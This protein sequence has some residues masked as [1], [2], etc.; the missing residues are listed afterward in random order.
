MWD[1]INRRRFP[2]VNYPCYIRVCKKKSHIDF[3]AHS[4]Q[5][6]H[7]EFLTQTENIS[8]GGIAVAIEK[9]LEL[10]E[11]V[12]LKMDLKDS[13]PLI[14]CD[15]TIVWVVKRTTS[16]EPKH[17]SFDTGVEFTNLAKK[18]EARVDAIVQRLM[19]QE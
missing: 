19:K 12:E 13:G 18:D 1:G 7:Q 11:A 5:R 16:Q 4:K 3:L 17:I 14:E 2:R 15:G 6:S 10:F 8:C 9:K